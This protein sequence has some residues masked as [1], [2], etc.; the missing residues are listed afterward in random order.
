MES[1]D[2]GEAIAALQAGM[3]AGLCHVDTAEAYGSGR[4]EELV[5]RALLGRREEAFL[6]SKVLPANAS[7]DGT[8]RACE[9]SL[10]R[11]GTDYLDCYLLH[12]PG[13]HPLADTIAALEELVR[14]GKNPQL[15]PQQF[16][17]GG[18]GRG[19]GAGRPGP[20]RLQ[21]G[22]VPPEGAGRGNAGAAVVRAPAGGGG[23]LQPLRLGTLSHPHQH[24]GQAAG[25]GGAGAWGDALPGG[26]CLPRARPPRLRHSQVGAGKPRAVQRC[27]C[28]AG[29][30][31]GGGPAA[32][33][34]L[35][36]CPLAVACR[37]CEGC[38][39]A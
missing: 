32:G 21:P 18:P 19:L 4:V 35:S 26:T 27:R 34:G 23:G 24:R 22:A 12:W 15:G 9:R 36:Q 28:R 16:R 39:R 6:V 30:D 10:R 8:L 7:R 3:D 5:G 38:R 2:A 37:R 25:E 33:N 1:D 29:A 17:C 11:L 13:P 14:A 31:R 20:H